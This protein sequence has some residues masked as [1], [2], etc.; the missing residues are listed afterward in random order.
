MRN[1]HH[2]PLPSDGGGKVLGALAI[3]SLV[4]FGVNAQVTVTTVAT[5]TNGLSEPYNVVVDAGNNVYLSDSA[6]NRIVRIDSATQ[7]AT[8]LAGL[9]SDAPGSNDGPPYLAHFN[10]PQGLL[11]ASI[12]GTN[13]LVVADSGNNLIRFVRFSDGTVSTLAGAD[14]TFHFPL[15]L[16]QDGNGN[17]YIADWGNNVIRVLN[18]NDP[19]FVV[20][21]VAVSG[22]TFNRPTAV[23]FAST[24]QLW[25]ADTGNQMVKQITLTGQAAGSLTTF[26]GA[27]RTTGTDDS[28]FGPSARFNSP[29]GLL[30]VTG[31]GLLISD[32]LNNSIR[33]ATNYVAFG[34][35]NYAV[36]TFAGTPGQAGLVDGSPSTAKFNSPYGLAED[37][38]NNGFLVA[39]LKNNAIRRIQIGPALP[40][41]PAPQIGWVLFVKDVFGAFVSQLQVGQSFT[42][43][44]DVIIAILGTDGTE[45]HFTFGPTP[46]NPLNDTVENPSANVGSSPPVYRNG[47]PQINVAPSIISPQPDVVIKA[48]GFQAGR[49]NSP[50]T[51]ARFQFRVANPVIVGNNAALFTISDQTVGAHMWY[52][53]DGSDPSPTNS[54]PSVGPIS[55]SSANLSIN[56]S[57]NFTFKIRAFRDNYQPSD[58]VSQVFSGTNFNATKITFGFDSGE[59]SSD[60]IASPGQIF[61][62]PVTLSILPGILMYS[63]QFNVTVT[64]A[65]PNPGPPITPGAVGFVSF[66]EKPNPIPPDFITIPPA[67][68]LDNAATNTTVVTNI[69][70]TNVFLTTNSF[71][72][73][74]VDPPPTNQLFTYGGHP[75]FLDLQFVNSSLN[76]IGVGWLERA[77]KTNLYDTTKQDLLKYS[78]PHD[79]LFLEDN[80][81]VVLGGYVFEVSPLARPGQTYRIQIGRPSATSDGIGAPGSE[82][83]IATPTN[84]ALAGGAIN[85]IKNVTVAQRKYIA[86]DCAPFRWFNAGDFGNTNLNNSDVEQVFQSSTYS[87][88]YPPDGSDFFD[89]MD[90]CGG[91]YLDLGHG[92]LEFDSSIRGDT[93]ALDALFGGDD[94]TIN[95]IAFGDGVLDVCDVYVTFR[96]SLD[97]SLVWFRRFWTNGVRGAEIIGNPPPPQTLKRVT[98]TNPPSI[99][100]ASADIRVSAGQTLEIPITAQIFGTYPLR[101]LMLNLSVNP[102]DGAP[103]LTSPLQFAPN[104]ALGQPTLTTSSGNGNYAGSWLNSAISG[105]TSNSTIGTLTVQIPASAS[106]SAAYAVHFDHASA[107]PNGL[108]SFP[109]HTQTGLITL[110]DRSGS[111]YNDGIPDSW[112]LRYFGTVYNLLSQANADADGDGANNWQEYIAGTDPT[113]GKSNLRV[114][115]DQAAALQ[116]QD[117]VIRW[118]SV[119]GK[120]YVLERSASLF[121][122]SWIPVSTNTGSGTDLEFHDAAGGNVRFY[123]VRVAP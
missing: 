78:Q 105:L 8:T 14:G 41:V 5:A 42:F 26:L 121:A 25:V 16:D 65:G 9:P 93:N 43:N 70:G 113:D 3:I 69:V 92:Y 72:T 88:D 115:T 64:N 77:G 52:T 1:P 107:S 48:I 123:R 85:S 116:R 33:L 67:M 68:F 15:G 44:N 32:T 62:A 86:G 17:V 11:V 83:Y 4:A 51:S 73:Y 74:P 122:P 19:A 53:I 27:Y 30:W 39:D 98:T 29:S 71:T 87:L 108:A 6:N 10:N 18:L 28:S 55:A 119:A 94:T 82:V 102:L 75:G 37:L 84:G 79:T 101:V 97:P 58:V 63:L 95:Q 59:A 96:R 2:G 114:S 13:G 31:V 103:A 21:T 49:K 12:G 23:A 106:S 118:P 112:R 76:L 20:S 110:S 54:P 99:N 34:P 56:A 36:V 80:S 60:F 45:T 111:S 22:T 81:E 89:S 120:Q 7:E 35:T 117:C 91:T 50:I 109:K 24:N 90:S 38:I 46:S 57:S 40:P 104:P 47:L 100:F 61:Y 66:L